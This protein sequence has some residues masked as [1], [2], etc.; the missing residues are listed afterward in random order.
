MKKVFSEFALYSIINDKH[1][2]NYY[3][4]VAVQNRWDRYCAHR[5]GIIE[6]DERV[7]DFIRQNNVKAVR[8]RLH[9]RDSFHGKN[10]KTLPDFQSLPFTEKGADRGEW[11]DFQEIDTSKLMNP[12]QLYLG[13]GQSGNTYAIWD[14][15]E[16]E[17][18]TDE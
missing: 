11:T 12:I 8:I 15:A 16:I 6:I 7:S 17:V 9:R 4:D 5:T 13:T 18:E 10:G 2:D 1:R 3:Y 14:R